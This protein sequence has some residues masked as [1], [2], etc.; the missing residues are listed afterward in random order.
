[1]NEKNIEYNGKI[2]PSIQSFSTAFG[3][4]KA[5]VRKY[6]LRGFSPETIVDLCS[7]RKRF[8]KDSQNSYVP[9]L[10]QK[11]IVWNNEKCEIIENFEKLCKRLDCWVED[12][13]DAIQFGVKCKGF[14]I[15][16]AF[17]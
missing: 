5:T 2:Y 15:D 3:F 14:F 4:P 9:S 6:F 12:A 11:F 13:R 1:M 7:F 8:R 17:E 10:S 16:E